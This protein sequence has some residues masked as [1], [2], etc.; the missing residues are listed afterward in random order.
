MDMTDDEVREAEAKSSSA[1]NRARVKFLRSYSVGYGEQAK[2]KA[3]PLSKQFQGNRKVVKIHQNVLV[4]YKG[5][6][7]RTRENFKEVDVSEGDEENQ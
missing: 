6:P 5:D 4:F 2:K 7:K 3:K 1:W